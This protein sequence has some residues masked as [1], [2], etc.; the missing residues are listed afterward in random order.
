MLDVPGVGASTSSTVAST[1]KQVEH[2]VAQAVK[3]AKGCVVE[4]WC[5]P[6][7]LSNLGSTVTQAEL[8]KLCHRFCILRFILTRIPKVGE[9]PQ[10][11][12]ENLGE[13]AF[14]MVAL[15]CGMRL[16]LAP[17]V[18]RLLSEFS[19]HSS[20]LAYFFGTLLSLM[21]PVALNS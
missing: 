18:K 17:F 19:L 9:L 1:T 14:S 8:N 6:C 3:Q 2:S 11:A 12:R 10:H 16:L 7:L 20:S 5:H 13:I 21:C 4:P 15:E